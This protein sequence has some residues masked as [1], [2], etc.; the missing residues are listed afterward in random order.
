MYDGKGLP[1]EIDYSE[2]ILAGPLKRREV[3]VT[4]VEMEEGWNMST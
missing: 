3:N 2:K 4:Y 1:R